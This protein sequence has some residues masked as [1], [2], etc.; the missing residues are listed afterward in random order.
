MTFKAAKNISKHFSIN[1]NGEA[2]LTA[3]GVLV[4]N[5]MD[6][7]YVYAALYFYD[8]A[9]REVDKLD[10]MINKIKT[11]ITQ[12]VYIENDQTKMLMELS[13]RVHRAIGDNSLDAFVK[14]I[15]AR[16]GGA[17]LAL[18]PSNDETKKF[19]GV[20]ESIFLEL[21]V[22][23]Y[24]TVYTKAKVVGMYRTFKFASEYVKTLTERQKRLV[25]PA[26]KLVGFMNGLRMDE[27]EL[28]ADW[29]VLYAP[30]PLNQNF[31][32][33][34]NEIKDR[35]KQVIAQHSG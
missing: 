35:L 14:E 22:N 17:G 12:E 23:F 5:A 1:G 34:E 16:D 24:E 11:E 25:S 4:D 18:V 3:G 8:E 10:K 2:I 27:L 15:L 29:S 26:L 7:G 9:Q 32:A 33:T 31:N 19:E 13:T 21:L 30:R 28:M 20:K 6:K